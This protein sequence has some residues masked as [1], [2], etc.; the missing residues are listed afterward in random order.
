MKIE[1][2]KDTSTTSHTLKKG[3]VVEIRSVDALK[4][5]SKKVAKKATET[6][7]GK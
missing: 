2:L 7:K 4:L 1:I 3:D 6:K 5:V